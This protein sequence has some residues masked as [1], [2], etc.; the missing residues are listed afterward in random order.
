MIKA[1]GTCPPSSGTPTTQTSLT[2]EC[3]AMTPSISVGEICNVQKCI[4]KCNQNSQRYIDTYCCKDFL[5]MIVVIFKDLFEAI[6]N[7]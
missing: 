3:C 7:E 5:Y 4:P 2:A 6:S 1:L